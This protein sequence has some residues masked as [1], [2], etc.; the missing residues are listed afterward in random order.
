MIQ[1]YEKNKK[2]GLYFGVFCNLKH[3]F[4]LSFQSSQKNILYKL[5]QT[6]NMAEGLIYLILSKYEA[7]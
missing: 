1:I 7:K 5:N 4:Y 6:A 2:H 3:F